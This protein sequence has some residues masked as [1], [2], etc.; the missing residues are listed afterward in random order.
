[1]LAHITSTPTHVLAPDGKEGGDGVVADTHRG[2]PLGNLWRVGR[3]AGWRRC[4]RWQQAGFLYGWRRCRRV[5]PVSSV[6]LSLV[7]IL[8]HSV[9]D[10]VG[11]IRMERWQPPGLLQGGLFLLLSSGLLG[12]LLLGCPLLSSGGGSDSCCQWM[13]P[14]FRG[15]VGRRER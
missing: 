14:S 2:T 12:S 9:R 4:N 10:L 1:M 8:R 6:V 7:L 3:E 11:R 13:Y 5:E 15:G